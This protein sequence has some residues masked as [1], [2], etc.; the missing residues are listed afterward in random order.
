MFDFSKIKIATT[1]EQELRIKQMEEKDAEYNKTRETFA[2]Y[3]AI[4]KTTYYSKDGNVLPFFRIDAQRVVETI[5]AQERGV[6]I[7]LEE[8]TLV[9]MNGVSGAERYTI[10]DGFIAILKDEGNIFDNEFCYHG[11]SQGSPAHFVFM[12]DMLDYIK[13]HRPEFF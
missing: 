4:M 2:G 12:D 8:N 11:G 10:D 3:K 7:R 13:R 9:F 5:N 1:P 6:D